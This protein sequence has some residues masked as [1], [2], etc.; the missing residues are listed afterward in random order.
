MASLTEIRECIAAAITD[1]VD[2][3]N[4]YARVP[5]SIAAP[6]VIVR[7]VG[8]QRNTMS[9][10]FV[11]YQFQ[12]VCAAATADNIHGQDVLDEMLATESEKSITSVFDQADPLGLA[13]TDADASGWSDYGIQQIGDRD[14]ISASIDLTVHTRGT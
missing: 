4:A 1:C 10:G 3:I 2:G 14:Y 7:P 8:Q 13:E 6:A 5:T 9:R 11:T 12:L